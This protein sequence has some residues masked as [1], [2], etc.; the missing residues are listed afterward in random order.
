[1]MELGTAGGASPKLSLSYFS[2]P[3]T[4]PGKEASAA[5]V[6]VNKRSNLVTAVQEVST[7]R[8]GEVSVGPRHPTGSP[9]GQPYRTGV[10]TTP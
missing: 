8:S 6:I 3:Q 1:V 4:I 7:H 9:D 5:I 10:T 2:T